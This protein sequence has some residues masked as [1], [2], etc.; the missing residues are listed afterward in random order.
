MPSP[1]QEHRKERPER[2]D[3]HQE[4]SCLLSMQNP[5]GGSGTVQPSHVVGMPLS[6]CH[7]RC[8]R[9]Q[10][11]HGLDMQDANLWES[12]IFNYNLMTWCKC[13]EVEFDVNHHL[14][15]QP[16]TLASGLLTPCEALCIDFLEVVCSDVQKH[17][18]CTL[19]QVFVSKGFGASV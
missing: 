13:T 9:K 5:A 14:K 16:I 15:C 4:H 6:F 17:H 3:C 11:W 8:T 19:G 1:C 18:F 12:T 2:Q 7:R 10:A